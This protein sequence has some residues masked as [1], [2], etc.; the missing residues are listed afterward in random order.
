MPR[1]LLSVSDK[2]G[3]IE[4]ARQLQAAG[5][6]LISTGGTYQAL[7]DAGIA[8]QEVSAVTQF[9]EM[10]DGRLKT[11]HPAIHG[12]LLAMR[13]QPSHM[14]AARAHG[15][16][17]IDYVV[18][19]L[20]P[21]AETIQKPGVTLPE[22]IEKID[23][24]GPTML[25]SAAKNYPFVATVV[26]PTDY[27]WIGERLAQGA[28]LTVEERFALAAKVFRHTAAYDARIAEYLTRQTGE[29][30]PEHLTLTFARAQGLRY[31]EN[32]HQKA[33]FYRR[34]PVQ[35]NSLA[36][37]RQLQGKELSYNN[38][39]DANAALELLAEFDRPTAV[40]VKHMNPCGVGTGET[41]LE[42]FSRAYDADP[43]SI[44]GGIVALN[45]PLDE[46][47]AARLTELFL[48][49]VIAPA[50]SPQAL[51]KLAKKRNVRV[52][53]LPSL[54][55]SED[56][57]LSV[58]SVTGG[59]LVQDLDL[60]QVTAADLTLVS[61]R[62][63]TSAEMDELLFAWRVVKHVKSNAIVLTKA[64]QTLG[65]GA[66]QMNRVGSAQI[67][68]AQAGAKAAGSVLA[69]DAFFPMPDTV[70]VAAA[71][72]VRAIIQPG[73]SIKDADSI[74]AAD[75]HGIAMVVTGVRHFKH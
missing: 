25:R 4:F 21:F 23:I 28:A 67:A 64:G 13:D 70:E 31:G 74:A 15:I 27:L 46:A 29:D 6:E 49:I 3:I 24:G 53:E 41:G 7:Q 1:A 51:V 58:K 33:A 52:L 44:F 40:A 2:Q 26:D 47:T 54:V 48:E 73:G 32:P 72:G 62:V 68:V 56:D 5:I 11:L 66:G 57:G 19:N 38:I 8:V 30:F 16:E 61:K 39:Q 22:A 14:E 60:R 69:S 42:A 71:A 75:A 18:V 37:A 36:G 55:R 34:E 17:M 12:G 35:R 59:L 43:I 10:M 45:R 9:P 65:I 50:F 63:P 20:Y